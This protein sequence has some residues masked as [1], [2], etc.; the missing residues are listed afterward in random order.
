M[1]VSAEE[2]KEQQRAQLS[3]LLAWL[4][5]RKR[6]AEIIGVSPQAIYGMVKNGRISRSGATIIH[7]VTEGRFDRAALRPD[8]TTWAEEL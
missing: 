5:S 2:L 1:I 3:Q 8:I 4:G 7:R 6:L